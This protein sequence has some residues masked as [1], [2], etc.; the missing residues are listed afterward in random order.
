MVQALVW[1]RTCLKGFFLT[2]RQKY[3]PKIDFDIILNRLISFTI[4]IT[5]L[6]TLSLMH[7]LYHLL[8]QYPLTRSITRDD[9]HQQRS[10]QLPSLPPWTYPPPSLPPTNYSPTITM[11]V[12]A[13]TIVTA[14]RITTHT[15]GKVPSY[16]YYHHDMPLA[17]T[18]TRA[19][20]QLYTHAAYNATPPP[21]L[22]QTYIDHLSVSMITFI[23]VRWI[24]HSHIVII[25]QTNWIWQICI[26]KWVFGSANTH[27]CTPE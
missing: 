18:H 25:V 21:Q 26:S 1:Q 20:I 6:F 23:Y 8:I 16:N 2:H 5:H 9:P 10:L 17:L 27:I 7:N 12:T 15:R 22:I 14:T 19:Y 13:T 3:K 4:R 11:Y 24:N